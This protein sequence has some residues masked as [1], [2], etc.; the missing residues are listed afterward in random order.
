MKW[1]GWIER[2]YSCRRG[3]AAGLLGSIEALR[4]GGFYIFCI[5]YYMQSLGVDDEPIHNHTY[6]GRR[7]ASP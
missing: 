6:E 1:S 4:E 5:N 7:T 3:E 2:R